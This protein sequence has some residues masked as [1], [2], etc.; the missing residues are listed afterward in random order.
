MKK[1]LVVFLIAY[2][3]CFAYDFGTDIGSRYYSAPTPP[4]PPVLIGDRFLDNH[5]MRMYNQSVQDYNYEMQRYNQQQMRDMQK[6]IEEL[7][8]QK[9]SYN[10]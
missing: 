5:K 1:I 10:Y 8:R 6:Q 9:S 7:K 4:T 2:S 3:A